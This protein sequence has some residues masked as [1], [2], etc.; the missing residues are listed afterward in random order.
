S[1]GG[2]AQAL[3]V[4]PEWAG[5]SLVVH[6]VPKYVGYDPAAILASPAVA[7]ANPAVTGIAAVGDLG[8]GVSD[9]KVV[10]GSTAMAYANIVPGNPNGM[11]FQWYVNGVPVPG[12][13]DGWKQSLLVRPE[14]LGK[15]LQV[16]L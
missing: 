13:Q 2:S 7:V 14:W 16:G 9:G 3:T 12:E 15:N 11:Y 8:R 6:V 4:R 1:Q 10:T 5:G